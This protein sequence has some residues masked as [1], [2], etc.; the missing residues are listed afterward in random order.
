VGVG[1]CFL[2]LFCHLIH[3]FHPYSQQA[4]KEFA[5]TLASEK[6]EVGQLKIIHF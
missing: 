3:D 6:E 4:K 5:A 1:L 2:R